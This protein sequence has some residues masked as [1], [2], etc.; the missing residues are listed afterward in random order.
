ASSPRRDRLKRGDLRGFW[1]WI[2]K[3]AKVEHIRFHDLRHTAAS[4]MLRRGLLPREVS[5]S[6]AIPRPE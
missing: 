4:E 5:T 3:K 6:S 1:R 2:K